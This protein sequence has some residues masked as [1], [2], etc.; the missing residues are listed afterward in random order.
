M[1]AATLA[2]ACSPLLHCRF[3]VSTGTSIGMPPRN[4]LMRAPPAP[5]PGWSTFPIWQSPRAL[6]NG[7]EQG[8]QQILAGCVL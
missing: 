3:T 7:L 8:C 1:L 6:D 4:W 2:T 5:A